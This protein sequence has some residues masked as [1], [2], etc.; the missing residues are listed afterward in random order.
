MI[1][2]AIVRIGGLVDEGAGE[3]FE[4]ETGGKREAGV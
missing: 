2:E 4:G 1:I 3:G